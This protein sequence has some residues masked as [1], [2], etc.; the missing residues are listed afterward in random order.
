MANSIPSATED[1]GAALE[2]DEYGVESQFTDGKGGNTLEFYTHLVDCIRD[3]G[4]DFIGGQLGPRDGEAVLEKGMLHCAV[5][6][7]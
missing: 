5:D 7:A 1:N 6:L 4:F 2:G 3:I